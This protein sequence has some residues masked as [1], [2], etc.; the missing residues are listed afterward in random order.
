LGQALLHLL[1]ALL[2]TAQNQSFDQLHSARTH[3]DSALRLLGAWWLAQQSGSLPPT[4]RPGESA[5]VARS[6]PAPPAP[7][8]APEDAVPAARWVP[9]AIRQAL[10]PDRT[11][12]CATVHDTAGELPHHAASTP[13][14][15]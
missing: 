9:V 1:S 4:A 2:A 3:L 7:A 13:V 12:R 14:R 5:P 10:A 8:A 6:S 11:V 15:E